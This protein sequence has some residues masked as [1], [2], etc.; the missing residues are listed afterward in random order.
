MGQYFICVFLA[1][2]CK[3]IR[4]FVSPHNY[5]NGAKLV[6]HSY[7]GIPFMD[8]VEF[9]LSPQGMFYKS[10]IVWA[11]DYADDEEPGKNL[12]SI[13]YNAEDKMVFLEKRTDCKFILNHTKKL[14]INKDTLGDIHPLAILTAEGNGRGN[15]DYHGSDEELCGSWAR[16]VIS[17]ESS[18]NGYT[19]FIHG[20]GK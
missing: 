9:M 10:R 2:D 17:V 1:E 8:A 20:F 13:A 15:G 12:Y 11:G 6:E 18:D 5:M 3:F 7:V 4:A 16:D 14:F 19:E